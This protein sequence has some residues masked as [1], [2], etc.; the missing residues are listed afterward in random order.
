MSTLNLYNQFSQ[1]VNNT[2][3]NLSC[4]LDI[5]RIK[6]NPLYQCTITGGMNYGNSNVPSSIVGIY[7]SDSPF[8]IDGSSEWEDTFDQPSV[9]GS[10]NSVT[11]FASNMS[12]KTQFSLKA[13]SL[14]EKRWSGTTSPKFS[15]RINIYVVRKSDKPWYTIM[16]ALQSVLGTFK[17]Y[18]GGNS[19]IQ[20]TE[21]SWAIYSP[22]NYRV[23]Y[24]SNSKGQDTPE[25]TYSISFG[26]GQYCWFRMN[27]IIID[28]V[29]CSI[30]N[31]KYEDGNPV[32]VTLDISFEFWRMPLYEDVIS[33][34]PLA[35]R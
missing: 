22:N 5:D 32:S 6:A 15:T 16:F 28:D 3:N 4:L 25:G 29:R 9:L 34:F 30:N 12:G 7:D 13:L 26:S 35:D 24:R 33:W 21:S 17:D 14:T 31:K 10:A 8:S 20:S 23:N 27:N 11:G 18:R 1:N 2:N 19:Q